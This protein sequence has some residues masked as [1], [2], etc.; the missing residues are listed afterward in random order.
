M[1]Q[2]RRIGVY[3]CHCGGNISDYVN[4][5]EVADAVRNDPNVVVSR[6]HM[7]TCSDAAQQEMIDEIKEKQLDGLVIA[8]CSPKLHMFTFRG[9][10][11]RANLNQYQYIHVNLREQCSWVHT[12]DKVGAT[13]KGIHLLRAGI[14]KCELTVPLNAIRIETKPRVLVVG[15]GVSGMRAAISLADM[16]LAVFLIER[17]AE[18]GGWALQ[19]GKMGPEAQDGTDVV[20]KLLTRINQHENIMLHTS[21]EVVSKSGSIGDFNVSVRLPGDET[22]SLNV[23][24]IVV[25]TGFEP[26]TPQTDEY[27]WGAPGV[28]PLKDFRQMLAEADGPLMHNGKPVRDVA[29]IYCVGSRQLK[30]ESC[31]EPNSYCSRY[32]CLATTYTATL[33]HDLEQKTGQPVNQ[34]H[35]YRDVRTYGALEPIYEKARTGGAIF[36]RWDPSNPPQ[37]TTEGDQLTV[38]AKDHLLGGE[39]LEI[40]ADLVVLATGM[41]PRENDTLNDILKIPESK[42]GFYNEIHLKL[43]PV[44]TMIDGVFIAGTAQGPKTLAESVASSLAAVAKTGGL[45]MKGYVD[46]EP[47]IAKV[48]TDKC[49]WCGECLKACPYGAIEKVNVGEKE[50]AFVIE[51]MCKGAGPCVPVCPHNAIEIE[52][53]RDDQITAMI[54]ASIKELETK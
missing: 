40:G 22:V 51:S 35:L 14:A 12:N 3:V 31:P 28:I 37:V 50:I 1:A 26:Y 23:G 47:L 30:S 8:S 38:K 43:R 21:A 34:Y 2:K 36:L 53:F 42:D 4:V 49:I 32:C 15:A 16:G 20:A 39:E 41:R 27:G 44:E 54:D 6:T 25:T 45:L 46:L 11:E 17:E 9:M 48:D 24:A 52:G 7:F 18:A 29:F 19:T 5:E 33:L 13:K 10:S